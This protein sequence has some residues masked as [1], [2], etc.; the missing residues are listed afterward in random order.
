[1]IFLIILP[2]AVSAEGRSPSGFYPEGD[3]G[4]FP[5]PGSGGG[6]SSSGSKVDGGSWGQSGF[7]VP[8]LATGVVVLDYEVG[9]YGSSFDQIGE[10]RAL[11]AAQRDCM[12]HGGSK[13][14]VVYVLTKRCA[15]LAQPSPFEKGGINKLTFSDG[16]T[17]LGTAALAVNDCKK[18]NGRACVVFLSGCRGEY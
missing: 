12:E 4:C 11:R 14:D 17:E 6:A 1:M 3:V 9:A 18:R 13:C 7:T 15:S 16:S 8:L 5:I 2:W 10:D